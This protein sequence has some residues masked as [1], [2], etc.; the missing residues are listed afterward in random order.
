M[1]SELT[2]LIHSSP[3]Y[4]LATLLA[5][6][7]FIG[8]IGLALRQ[9]MV[10]C[11]IAVGIIVGPS[12]LDIVQNYESVHILAE[13]GI[14]VL[15][16]L[17]GLKLDLKLI[18][19]LGV[20]SLAT[21]LGQVIF[22]SLFGF[23]IA[24]A[25]GLAPL[26]ALY[27]AI[28][29]TFSST[30]I[31]VKLLSDKRE[32]ESLHG[33]V[34]I[35]FLIVQDLAVVFAMLVLSSLGIGSGET[36]DSA[37]ASLLQVLFN[38]AMMLIAI[39]LIVKY[40]AEPLLSKI[41]KSPELLVTFT[42]AWAA[43]F[44]ALGSHL[45]FSMELGGLLAGVAFAST[46]YR[47]SIVA[48]LAPLRDFLLLFFFIALGT[49]LDLSS[50]QEQVL[51]ALILSLFVLVGNPLIVMVI[52][53]FMGF[54]KRTG[55]FAGLTVAQISEFSLIFIAMGIT[56]GHVG[57]AELSLVTLVGL[58][59]ISLSVYMITYSQTLYRVL[60]PVLGVFERKVA[61]R[62]DEYA[63]SNDTH[64]SYDVVIVGMG[65]FGCH[66]ADFAIEKG[67]SV[68][69]IDFDPDNVRQLNEQGRPAIYGDVSDLEFVEKM[70]VGKRWVVSTLPT[71]AIGV[72]HM[73]PR[74]T[75]LQGLRER[76][77]T[78]H[79]A[80]AANNRHDAER[81]QQQ[82]I[83]LVLLPFKDAAEQVIY[84]MF[85]KPASQSS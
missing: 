78:G 19:T 23:G 37:L 47:E 8:V 57:Q 62:E 58:I 18:K 44:A 12:A 81:L 80:I 66:I 15:L 55:L 67:Y 3:F 43:L 69:A 83:D 79:I 16:F 50:L 59:T 51:P 52:M 48:R 61:H 13:L 42:I 22:T 75:L 41:A 10:V 76:N 73:D 39:V 32:V 84:K 45:G 53:G 49:Q 77:Y 2:Q 56:V 71:D 9:P 24:L 74:L 25:L 11:F 38:A 21:G 14:A 33:K 85:D 64:K 46:S 65:R 4:E 60:E 28:A 17:V 63:A 30:I 20:V 29:L 27:V 72:T 35:G 34:A 31:I 36:D 6:A 26:P 82:P 7:A 5:L 68:L 54:R 40:L 70:P 1:F